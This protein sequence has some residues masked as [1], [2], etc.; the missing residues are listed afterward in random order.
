MPR[1]ARRRPGGAA[2]EDSKEGEASD[3]VDP[4]PPHDSRLKVTCLALAWSRDLISK[5]KDTSP[6]EHTARARAKGVK[7]GIKIGKLESAEKIEEQNILIKGR[8]SKIKK[9]ENQIKN[10]T[11]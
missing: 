8:D 3:G 11:E 4:S 9:Q 6:A 7:D 5:V 10:L 1:V 2:S